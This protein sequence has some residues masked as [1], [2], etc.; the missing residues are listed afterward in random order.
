MPS[1]SPAE[2]THNCLNCPTFVC[3]SRPDPNHRHDIVSTISIFYSI[4]ACIATS[5]PEEHQSAFKTVTLVK[6]FLHCGPPQFLPSVPKSVKQF[7]FSFAFDTHMCCGKK[8]S[9]DEVC[10]SPTFGFFMCKLAPAYLFNNT[11]HSSKLPGCSMHG[12]Q[13]GA[14]LDRYWFLHNEI[15]CILCLK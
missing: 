6:K 13:P 10:T 5:K 3:C 11:Y 1:L 2:I 14:S 7:N 12:F 15:E 8:L 9:W 4:Y